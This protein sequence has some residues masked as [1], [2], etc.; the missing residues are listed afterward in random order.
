MEAGII[1]NFKLHYK[2]KL[3][4]HYIREVDE[5]GSFERINLKQAVYLVKDTGSM[6]T[7]KKNN[8]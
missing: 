7:E 4:Q 8:Y 6:V 1:K 3:M 2:T 5:E